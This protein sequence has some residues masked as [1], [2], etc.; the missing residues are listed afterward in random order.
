MKISKLW[1]SAIEQYY[2]GEA[3]IKIYQMWLNILEICSQGKPLSGEHID[4]TRF[5]ETRGEHTVSLRAHKSY[6]L[7][8][9]SSPKRI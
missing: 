7:N 1:V 5:D 9:Q 6:R 3:T 2:N 4:D 8:E